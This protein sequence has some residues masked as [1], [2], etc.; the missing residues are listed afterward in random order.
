MRRSD[1]HDKQVTDR[2]DP[3]ATIKKGCPLREEAV[4]DQR[5]QNATF[6]TWV[7]DNTERSIIQAH[8]YSKVGRKG[9]K[10]MNTLSGKMTVLS[11]MWAG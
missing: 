4:R 1:P 11:S 2:C 3:R 5:N 7:L 9:E 8:S 10:E 6:L